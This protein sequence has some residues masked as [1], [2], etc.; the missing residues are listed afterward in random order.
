M[1]EIFDINHKKLNRIEILTKSRREGELSK[2]TLVSDPTELGEA[3]ANGV[4]PLDSYRTI[5][6]VG[7]QF[8]FAPHDENFKFNSRD[9][10]LFC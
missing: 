4:F 5:H 9:N 6:C 1:K 7:V 2:I 3:T 8:E 10:I